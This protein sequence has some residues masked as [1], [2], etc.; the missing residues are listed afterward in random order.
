MVDLRI[1]EMERKMSGDAARAAAEEERRRR[2]AALVSTR[3]W[4]DADVEQ[5]TVVTVERTTAVEC[6]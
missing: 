2:E 1:K 5:T 4:L 6:G 3:I